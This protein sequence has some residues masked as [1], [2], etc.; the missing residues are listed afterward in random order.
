MSAAADIARARKVHGVLAE[1]ALNYAEVAMRYV[2]RDYVRSDQ[3]LQEALDHLPPSEIRLRIR[4]MG[5]LARVRLH[6]G[7][8]DE[9]RAIGSHAI[10]MAR[11]QNDPATLATA[12]GALV[13]FPLQPHE[14]EEALRDAIEMAEAGARA[15]DLEVTIRAHFR[16]AILLLELGDIQG[17]SAAVEEMARL[18]THLRQPF[19]DAYVRAFEARLTL[20]RGS[21]GEA[22]ELIR[23]VR[24]VQLGTE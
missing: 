18:N 23:R 4:L 1:I 14:T 16:R 24:L 8:L 22:E 10:A 20:M 21:L 6:N 3:L 5:S 19:F 7:R 9:A 2:A 11:Q 12:L 17:V 13:E 15:N